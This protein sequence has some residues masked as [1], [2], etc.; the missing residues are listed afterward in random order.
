MKSFIALSMWT[1]LVHNVEDAY[2]FY[3]KLKLRM[4]EGGFNL[5]SFASTSPELRWR[6]GHNE[7]T[8]CDRSENPHEVSGLLQPRHPTR[9]S[10]EQQVLGAHWNTDSDQV[11]IDISN[12]Y[13]AM[14]D[15]LPTKRNTVIAL[16]P[17][18]F[19]D[20]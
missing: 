2:E 19:F 8:H 18:R 1:T 15:S 20:P 9:E 17:C 6:I 13:R 12:I 5:R 11:I 10:E 14:K 16:P 4:A 3:I 7:Q